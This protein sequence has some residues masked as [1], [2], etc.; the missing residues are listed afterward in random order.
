MAADRALAGLNDGIQCLF[1]VGG[2][3]FHR[4]DQVR[5]EILALFQLNIDISEG[6]IAALALGD[7]AI[8]NAD[9]KDDEQDDQAQDDK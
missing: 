6:L 5:N 7:Q 8:V 2:I 9:H 3:A 4:L 1:L